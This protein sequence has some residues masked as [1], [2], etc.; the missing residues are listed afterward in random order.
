M[1]YVLFEIWIWVVGAA[2]VGAVFGWWLRSLRAHRQ[3]AREALLWQRRIKR[4]HGLAAGLRDEASADP[5]RDA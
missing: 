5:K 4:L 1:L 2:L 3:V